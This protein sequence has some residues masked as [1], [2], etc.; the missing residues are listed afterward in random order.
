M[1]QTGF[2]TPLRV[3]DVDDTNWCLL[4]NLVFNGTHG[5]TFICKAGM[6]TDFASTP[7]LVWIILPRIGK[8]TK[9]AVLHDKMCD[10]LNA[11]YQI[12]K[13]HRNTV[14]MKPTFSSIDTDALFRKNARELGTDPIRSELLWLGVRLGALANPARRADWWST[15]PRVAADTFAVLLVLFLII[16]GIWWVTH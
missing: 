11:I 7:T 4:D 14:A 2:V 15:A 13:T 8:W 3:E 9:A 10:E 12:N 6:M 16:L 5:D 1:K